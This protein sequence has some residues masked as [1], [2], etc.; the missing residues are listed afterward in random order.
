MFNLKFNFK[1]SKLNIYIC[2]HVYRVFLIK[3]K[4]KQ[5]RLRDDIFFDLSVVRRHTT[6]WRHQSGAYLRPFGTLLFIFYKHYL[7]N[8]TGIYNKNNLIRF[9]VKML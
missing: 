8:S 2:A 4:K 3:K 5:N 1:F 9:I 6:S 7:K